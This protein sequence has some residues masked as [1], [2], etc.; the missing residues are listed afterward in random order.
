MEDQCY[1]YRLIGVTVHVGSAEGGHYY[2]LIKDTQSNKW[3]HFNDADVKPFDP[4][5]IPHE[6]FGG[7]MNFPLLQG[8]HYDT[9]SDKYLDFP[10]EKTNSAYMLF[11]ERVTHSSPQETQE[12][13]NF[14]LSPDLASWIWNDN[15]QFLKDRSIFDRMYFEHMW[16]M[17]FHIPGSLPA[18]VSDRANH[19]AVV[20]A[21]CFLLES[22]IHA[23][24]KV[25]KMSVIS[26]STPSIV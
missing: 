19:Q 11:Y 20:L 10:I 12:T 9:V 7:E 22:F 18:N 2:N 8:K 4:S 13:Y 5:N 25:I 23:K 21:S 6:A 15:T 17:C 24:E 3:Y 1:E 16:Q 26:W 14:E